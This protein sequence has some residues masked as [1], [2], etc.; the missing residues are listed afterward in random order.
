M[1]IAVVAT[2]LVSEATSKMV[3]N[4]TAGESSSNVNRPTAACNT[5]FP[6]AN[7]A[8]VAPGNAWSETPLRN[9]EIA[10]SPEKP[11]ARRTTQLEF[12]PATVKEWVGDP[13][14]GLVYGS[15]AHR[16]GG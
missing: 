4:S 6:P 12:S 1:A 8:Q 2:I 10:S 5:I 13:L 15:P 7:T 9:S 14:T 11:R 3:A 16:R